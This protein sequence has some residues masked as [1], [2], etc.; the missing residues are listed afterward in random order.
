MLTLKHYDKQYRFICFYKES[1]NTNKMGS[2]VSVVVSGTSNVNTFFFF[3]VFNCWCVQYVQ[4]DAC[5][6]FNVWLLSYTF[7]V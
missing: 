3:S 1:E 4:A 5:D 7:S 2:D 6:W